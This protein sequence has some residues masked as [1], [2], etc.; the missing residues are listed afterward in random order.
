MRR[1]YMMKLHHVGETYYWKT[2]TKQIYNI[3]NLESPIGTFCYQK[4]YQ[5]DPPRDSYRPITINYQKQNIDFLIDSHYRL[6]DIDN[7]Y[8]GIYYP[9][10]EFF[11]PKEFLQEY[12][13]TMDN[14]IAYNE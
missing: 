8:Y 2:H 12:A 6:Y 5:F 1:R 13:D 14:V 3:Y 7:Y 10:S 4:G 9:K 11:L